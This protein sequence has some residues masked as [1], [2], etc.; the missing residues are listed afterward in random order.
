MK[1]RRKKRKD[2][3]NEERTK[4]KSIRTSSSRS[5]KCEHVYDND[6]SDGEY[7]N[8]HYGYMKGFPKC[9]KLLH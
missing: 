7:L 8:C 6:F 9:N 4:S 1:R 3:D 5:Y 2:T